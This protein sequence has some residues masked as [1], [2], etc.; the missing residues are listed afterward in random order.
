MPDPDYKSLLDLSELPPQLTR[1]RIVLVPFMRIHSAVG[2]M[3]PT[4]THELI[5]ALC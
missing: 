3:Q 4:A 5:V 1:P 2:N